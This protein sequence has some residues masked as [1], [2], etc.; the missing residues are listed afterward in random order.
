MQVS[1]SDLNLEKILAM[2]QIP[3]DAAEYF[4]KWLRAL[5][6]KRIRIS[7][8]MFPPFKETDISEFVLMHEL[9]ITNFGAP[10]RLDEVIDVRLQ[11]DTTTDFQQN[12][13]L[14]VEGIFRIAPII[15]DGE[16]W[17]LYEIEDARLISD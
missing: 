4:P 7:G 16:L 9:R 8:Y 15:E 5:E 13:K 14:D 11:K 1:F 6:G 17:G 12:K 2:Q 3:I 10:I